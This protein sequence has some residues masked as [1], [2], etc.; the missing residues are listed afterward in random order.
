MKAII[1]ARVSTN[2]QDTTRQ[3]NDLRKYAISNNLDVV[4]TFQDKIS[5]FKKQFS[6]RQS[7]NDMFSYIQSNNI[8]NILVSELS[9]IT[10]RQIDLLVFVRECSSKGICIHTQK[11]S[12]R[13][14]NDDGTE[15]GNASMLISIISSLAQEESKSLSYRIKSG[16]TNAI[17]NGKGFN[18]KTYGYQPDEHGRP[19]VNEQQA[20]VVHTIFNLACDGI[21]APSIVNLLNDNLENNTWKKGRVSSI[22]KNTMYYGKMKYNDE[23]YDVPSIIDKELYDKA[24]QF[25]ISRSRFTSKR[26]H[27]NP[28]SGIIYCK[29]GA[30]MLQVVVQLKNI[31]SCRGKCGVKGINRPFLIDE[32]RTIGENNAKLS[33]EDDVRSRMNDSLQIEKANLNKYESNL[34]KVRDRKDSNYEM[35][36]DQQVTKTQYNKFNSKFELQIDSLT[37]SIEQCTVCIRSLKDELSNDIVH[38][39]LDIDIL[40][41][42]L[43]GKLQ[44]ITIHKDFIEVKF[45]NWGK[46]VLVAYRGQQLIKHR[47]TI[48]NINN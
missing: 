29:C 2:D 22:L 1:Y 23:Y 30:P 18:T 24:Q 44:Y 16:R 42:Q 25:R 3:I 26:Q 15:N 47:N 36:L 33:Q 19:I 37:N 39:S 20:I 40:K 35:Y 14:L 4:Q 32:V 41:K 5:G 7:W 13:T 48:N 6:E 34:R 28:F 11:E 46:Q 8:N 38:Y 10:R 45:Y 9:R 17:L 43:I 31:Y 21:G 27:T 12:I